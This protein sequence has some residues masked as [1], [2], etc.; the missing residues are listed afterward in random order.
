MDMVVGLC[1]AG[2]RF[3]VV[4]GVSARL[5]G[6][7]WLTDDLDICYSVTEENLRALA[8]ALRAWN[9][10]YREERS[11]GSPESD[12]VDVDA[13]RD[14]TILNLRTS[15]G[16]I[17][18]LSRVAGVGSYEACL[19]VSDEFALPGATPF[20][21]LDVPALIEAKR[22]ADRPRDREHI[23]V[24]EAVLVL[25][26]PGFAAGAPVALYHRLKDRLGDRL[27]AD[28]ALT[29]AAG[30]FARIEQLE[31]TRRLARND[32]ER[33]AFMDAELAALPPKQHLAGEIREL[34]T[35]VGG[36]V[37]RLSGNE[38]AVLHR[39]LR[40]AR[41]QRPGSGPRSR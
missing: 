2:V 41:R 34:A 33:L 20:A 30:A 37:R 32:A 29:A 39:A 22:A 35:A 23:V 28:D 14:S 15:L 12:E 19:A 8:F 16:D 18:V 10:T 17:D 26:Q 9:A 25:S 27:T 24:L 11:P 21:A 6:S 5:H 31:R 36:R 13:L 38:T 7:D 40:L 4:G 3:V 1:D